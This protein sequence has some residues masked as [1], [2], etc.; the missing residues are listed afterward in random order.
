MGRVRLQSRC[1]ECGESGASGF[2]KMPVV[3]DLLWASGIGIL[4]CNTAIQGSWGDTL[5][6]PRQVVG[7]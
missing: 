6:G 4:H 2:V 7:C 1:S 3:V 5:I